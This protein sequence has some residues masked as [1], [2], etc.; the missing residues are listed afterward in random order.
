MARTVHYRLHFAS[1]QSV[2]TSSHRRQ[3][4]AV[5]TVSART[6][7]STRRERLLKLGLHV[8][9]SARRIALHLHA[10]FPFRAS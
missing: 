7:A 4:H 2:D 3:G 10:S 6:Q 8:A 9:V 1:R 5:G